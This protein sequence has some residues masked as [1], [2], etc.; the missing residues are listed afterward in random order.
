MTEEGWDLRGNVFVRDGQRYLPLYEA[1]LFHQ[2]D[3]RFATF[4]GVS[5]QKLKGGKARP[6]TPE[7]KADPE[8]VTLPRY[9]VPEAEV[10]K[11]LDKSDSADL[12]LFQ[13]NPKAAE[14]SQRQPE[15]ARGQRPDPRPTR[16]TG[17]QLA[18]SILGWE[19]ALRLITTS[20]N[21]RTVI[22]TLIPATGLGH[23][24]AIVSFP[25]GFSPFERQRI[26]QTNE[27][28]SRHLSGGPA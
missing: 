23:K 17:S 27:P 19:V 10:A 28:L 6:M 9:W 16:P 2:Y 25:Y 13:N 18:P 5:K 3:H 1:K 20:T 26:Q 22:S 8:A 4:E 15:A 21:E 12:P 7:E 24:G 14:G 11:R